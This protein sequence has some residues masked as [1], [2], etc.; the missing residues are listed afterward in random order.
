PNP[1]ALVPRPPL[2]ARQQPPP[3]ARQQPPPAARQ[4][5]PPAARQQPPPAARQ[6][7]P[8]RPAPCPGARAS[9]AL[10]ARPPVAVAVLMPPPGELREP[11][12]DL[13]AEK[14]S[15]FRFLVPPRSPSARVPAGGRDSCGRRL[16]ARLPR[17]LSCSPQRL[18]G[19][20]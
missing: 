13:G 18:Q 14:L 16:R 3:A 8:Q 15:R 6:Q 11:L 4:Q 19:L 20:M 17:L 1:L 7:P 10:G 5:P 2:A 12:S 9:P